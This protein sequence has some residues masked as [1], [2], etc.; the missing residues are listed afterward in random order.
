MLSIVT[1]RFE[2]KNRREYAPGEIVDSRGWPKEAALHRQP[3]LE[4]APDGA[5]VPDEDAGALA[6]AE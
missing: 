5:T 4:P 1:R 3:Y 6:N 2:G